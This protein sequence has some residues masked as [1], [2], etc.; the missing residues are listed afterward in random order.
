MS[1]ELTSPRTQAGITTTDTTRQPRTALGK[2]L[3]EIRA[4]IV[5]SGEQLMDWEEVELEI[6][7]RRGGAQN[8]GK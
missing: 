6:A 2:Q 4:K 8:G 7:D 3:M 5:A 1:K